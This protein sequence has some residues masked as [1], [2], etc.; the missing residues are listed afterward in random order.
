[1]SLVYLLI[2]AL[3]EIVFAISMKYADGFARPVPSGL[4]F[5]GLLGGLIFLTLA[6]KTMPVSVAYPLWTGIGTMGAVLFG[7]ILFGEA[8]SSMKLAFVFLILAGIIG[9]KVTSARGVPTPDC[10][11]GAAS[12]MSLACCPL[13]A[14]P[15][16]RPMTTKRPAVTRR[17]ILVLPAALALGSALTIKQAW[18]ARKPDIFVQSG[19]VFSKAWTHALDGHDTVAYFTDDKPVPGDARFETS[20][21]GAKWL[22]ASQ[23]N[24]DAFTADPDAYRPQYGSYCAYALAVGNGLV[25][26]DPEAWHIHDGKLYVNYDQRTQRRWLKQKEAYI[27]TADGLWPDALDA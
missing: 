8:L 18:A 21:K 26:G 23:D 14:S 11:H 3:F 9:L 27:E 24:L 4:A 2:A 7:A 10:G 25:K 13:N 22:F 20:F 17:Q 6:M 1:M 15:E 16:I 12:D 5:I 19:G